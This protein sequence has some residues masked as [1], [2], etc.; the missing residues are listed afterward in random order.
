[1][2]KDC[3]NAVKNTET[4]QSP[5]I[6]FAISKMADMFKP[7]FIIGFICKKMTDGRLKNIDH[8]TPN[9]N[10]TKSFAHHLITLS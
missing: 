1:M 3:V 2:V 5:I 8:I 4:K 9:M 7:E 6:D 10:N